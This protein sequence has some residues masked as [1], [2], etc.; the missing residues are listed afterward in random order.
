MNA[1]IVLSLHGSLKDMLE[2][3]KGDMK[4]VSE[5]VLFRHFSKNFDKVY[6]FSHDK[7]DFS[8]VLPKNFIQVKIRNN[9]LYAALGWVSVWWHAVRKNMKVV[10]A[11]CG[12]ALPPLFMVNKMSGAKT[13][14]NYDN[15]WYVSATGLK[16]KV[17]STY[18]KF[19]L[20][21]VNYFVI[22]S[23]EIK[24][25][26]GDREGILPI[27]KGIVLDSFDPG[28]VKKDALFGKINGRVIIFTGRLHPVK[29]PL[30]L[31]KAY[32]KAKKEVPDMHMVLA[33]DGPLRKECEKLADNDVHFTGFVKNIPS[34]LKGSYA[35]VLPSVYDASPR[36]L[37][38]AMAMELPSIVTRV[39]GV[40]D[41]ID[42]KSGIIIEPGDPDLLSEKIVYL[43][44]NPKKAKDMG[45]NARKR[46][47]K[48]HDIERNVAKL[49]SILKAKL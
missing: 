10:Y 2:K 31:M 35:F 45:K 27:K 13:V 9:K 26:V 7:E 28:K 6:L 37:M 12:P 40:P 32:R 3:N 16:R 25:F 33:G 1:G 18:E 34:L 39:G 44:K 14:L 5:F 48:D 17:I 36:S 23:T 29:D 38:E 24:K 43:F 42:E 22:A 4:R 41:Y 21:F 47:L 8:E 30:T 20:S 15:T 11:E 49:V 46:M 19:L